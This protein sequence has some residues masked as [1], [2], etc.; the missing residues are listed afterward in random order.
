MLHQPIQ[1]QHNCKRQISLTGFLC[2]DSNIYVKNVLSLNNY[3]RFIEGKLYNCKRPC[4]N[5]NYFG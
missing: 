4:L 1:I 2:P 3:V 5:K